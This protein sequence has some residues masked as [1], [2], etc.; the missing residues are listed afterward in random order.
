MR[1]ADS[2]GDGKL[3]YTEFKQIIQVSFFYNLK[4]TPLEI[5]KEKKETFNQIKF[6]GLCKTYICVTQRNSMLVQSAKQKCN[7]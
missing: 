3:S 4:I 1:A 6:A 7:P 2:D 5:F